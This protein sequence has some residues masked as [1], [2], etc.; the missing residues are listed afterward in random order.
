[1]LDSGLYEFHSEFAPVM[2]G[3]NTDLRAVKCGYDAFATPNEAGDPFFGE[4]TDTNGHGTSVAAILGG[5]TY[6]VAKQANLISVKVHDTHRQ[7]SLSTMLAG[8]DFVLTKKLNDPQQ[9]MVANISLGGPRSDIIKAA[10]EALSDSG[11]VVVVSAGN[12]GD[13]SCTKAPA[14]SSKVITVSATN[15][16]DVKPAYAN[17]G[18]CTDI[19]SP[20]HQITSAWIRNATDTA[21]LSGTSMAAAHVAGGTCFCNVDEFLS[22]PCRR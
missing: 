19:F 4:C 12:D 20:G 9:P 2:Y 3:D 21:R 14:S 17:D 5:I 11:I 22:D 10:V 1:M 15:Y 16:L 13:S 8:L 18:R 6:G 7:G